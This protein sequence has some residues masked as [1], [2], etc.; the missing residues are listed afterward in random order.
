MPPADDAGRGGSDQSVRPSP[1]REKTVEHAYLDFRTAAALLVSVSSWPVLR[2]TRALAAK[3]SDKVKHLCV[4]WIPSEP[5]SAEEIS[6]P[7]GGTCLREAPMLPPSRFILRLLP[8]VSVEK[9]MSQ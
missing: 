1:R 6:K 9:D 8:K 7:R 5:R 4:I 3:C 2:L